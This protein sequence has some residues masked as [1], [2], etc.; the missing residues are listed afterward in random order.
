MNVFMYDTQWAHYLELP[1]RSGRPV[2]I[3]LI[4]E[5]RMNAFLIAKKVRSQRKDSNHVA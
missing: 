5:Q 4:L 1:V 3:D 2:K